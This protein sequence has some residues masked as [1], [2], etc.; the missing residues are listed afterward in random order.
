MNNTFAA[1]LKYEQLCQ[2]VADK[3]LQE[4]FKQHTIQRCTWKEHQ[5][6]QKKDIDVMVI[7]P[8]S[9]ISAPG[10][11]H[12]YISEKFR[13]DYWEDNLIEIYSNWDKKTPG[14][15]LE[16]MAHMHHFYFQLPNK[17]CPRVR[18]IPTWAIRQ[19]AKEF[20]QDIDQIVEDMLEQNIH[21]RDI[22]IMNYEAEIILTPTKNENKETE[23]FGVCI[24][25][26]NQYFFDIKSGIKQFKIENIC[27]SQ[28]NKS[29][30]VE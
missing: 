15:G 25:I 30:N 8:V 1:A 16:S 29:S 2:P 6:L 28:D 10:Y 5:D 19:A 27:N 9:S 24:A 21:H 12:W 13:R 7:N 3:W 17:K 18:T 20:S 4:H 11:S 26:P 22:T 23:Y 14:W